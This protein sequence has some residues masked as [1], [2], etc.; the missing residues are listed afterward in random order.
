MSL[1]HVAKVYREVTRISAEFAEQNTREHFTSYSMWMV[2]VK[3]C[4]TQLPQLCV[5]V[6]RIWNRVV[7]MIFKGEKWYERFYQDKIWR[8]WKHLEIVNEVLGRGKVT[9]KI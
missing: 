7:V 8:F 2:P 4:N 5:T 1:V 3:L 9:S 6:H